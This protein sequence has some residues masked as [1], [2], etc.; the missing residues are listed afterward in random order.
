VR[1]GI[2]GRRWEETDRYAV[3]TAD[4]L[5]AY[6]DRLDQAAGVLGAK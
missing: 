4:V 6:S 3:L 1:E 5:N 2:E